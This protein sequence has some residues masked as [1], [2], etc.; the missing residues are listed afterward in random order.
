MGPR[1]PLPALLIGGAGRPASREPP[2]GAAEVQVGEAVPPRV[3]S[4]SGGGG[5]IQRRYQQRQPVALLFSCTNIVIM[6]KRKVSLYQKRFQRPSNRAS[7]KL[8]AAMACAEC[9]R[10]SVGDGESLRSPRSFSRCLWW[11]FLC[12]RPS[13]SVSGCYFVSSGAASPLFELILCGMVP[14]SCKKQERWTFPFPGGEFPLQTAR[15]RC[16]WR[17][18]RGRGNQSVQKEVGKEKSD[19]RGG[20]SHGGRARGGCAAMA[21]AAAGEG[22]PCCKERSPPLPPHARRCRPAR[23]SCRVSRRGGRRGGA[24]RPDLPRSS[25]RER[26][27]RRRARGRRLALGH[28]LWLP[29][30]EA[31][32]SAPA[33][34][35]PQSW[36]GG[37][38]PPRPPFVRRGDGGHLRLSRSWR[39]VMSPS[40]RAPDTESLAQGRLLSGSGLRLV[41]DPEETGVW[42]AVLQ[43]RLCT[44]PPLHQCSEHGDQRGYYM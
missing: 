28:P 27:R 11:T 38:R 33:H 40:A 21:P 30:A 23:A 29:R 32:Q 18:S 34:P 7:S 6:P 31:A 3:S 12:P 4:S 10:D 13:P 2:E 41:I 15:L 36:E 26:R 17:E 19:R 14:I 35:H 43:N 8:V 25:R 42:R 22:K 20:R 37:V 1:G 16:V 39:T 9:A 44:L 5:H 24:V